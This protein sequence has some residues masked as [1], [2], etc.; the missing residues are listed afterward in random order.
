MLVDH[1][2]AA[3]SQRGDLR[4]KRLR[5]AAGGKCAQEAGAQLLQVCLQCGARLLAR[6][7]GAQERR[8]EP[9]IV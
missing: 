9:C 8:V 2:L 3:L 4:L 6:L 1:L 7:P 5:V